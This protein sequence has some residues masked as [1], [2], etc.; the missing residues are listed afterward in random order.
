MKIKN[1]K[2]ES[3]ILNNIKSIVIV[4]PDFIDENTNVMILLH[5]LGGNEN[6]FYNN[7][8]LKS[9]CD[10]YNVVFICPEANDSWYVHDYYNYINE[11]VYEIAK[12]YSNTI[13]ISGFSMGGYGAMYIGL[14]NEKYAAIG[15]ISGSID[16]VTRDQEKRNDANVYESWVELFGEKLDPKFNLFQYINENKFMYITI[17]NNDH[18][19]NSNQNF[20]N[21]ITHKKYIYKESEGVHSWDY[22]KKEI[23]PMICELTQYVNRNK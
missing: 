18:L 13:I 8:D 1:I 22:V 2:L 5:G 3:K 21:N 23:E 14:T 20:K 11:E 7:T 6:D 17:G 12:T 16:I 10:K 19:L 9:F 4:E 15:S